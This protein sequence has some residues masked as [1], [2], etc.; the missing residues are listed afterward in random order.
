MDVNLISLLREFKVALSFIG[1]FAIT[2]FLLPH[3]AKLASIIGLVDHPN[4]RKIH[5]KPRPLVGGLAM[6]L[7]VALTALLFIP[8]LNLRGFYAGVVILV[9]TGALDDFGEINHRYKFVAQIIA[10]IFVMSLSKVALHTFGNIL[11]FGSISF[12][13]YTVPMTIIGIVGV[14]NAIN[15]IDGLDGLA[16]GI[17]LMAFGTFAF[18][19]YMYANPVLML[20]NLSICGSLIAFL[21]YNWHPAKLFMGDAGSLFLGFAA[22]YMSIALT[23]GTN[24]LVTPVT[25]LL[26][27][28]VPIVDTLTIMTKRVM[29]GNNPFRADKGHL[30]HIVLKMGFS[31]RQTALIIIL[32][33]GLFCSV[34]IVGSLLQIPEYW[35]F[36][37]FMAYFIAYFT[38]SF[39]VRKLLRNRAKLSFIQHA[40]AV[41]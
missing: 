20:L 17:C 18:L 33:S 30:H 35:L 4:R 22:A 15:M 26:V 19:S 38:A 28:A 10:A 13:T 9:I 27:L 3:F 16:G 31:K 11:P 40:A 23:Q 32:L 14:C 29:K 12:V 1:P 7:G 5:V 41:K 6:S 36:F 21:I 24:G 34:A 37:F 8:L 2:L 39:F 25:P